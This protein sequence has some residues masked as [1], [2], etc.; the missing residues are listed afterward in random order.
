MKTLN[1]P[2][3]GADMETGKIVKWC[4]EQGTSLKKGDVVALIEIAKGLIEMEVFEDC[5]I[6][7]FLVGLGE[8]IKVGEPIIKVTGI[9]EAESFE[10]T[11]ATKEQKAIEEKAK[12]PQRVREV[13]VS[14]AGIVPA[15]GSEVLASPAAK[16]RAFEKHINLAELEGT[17]PA[18][19]ICLQDVEDAKPKLET[20]KPKSAFDTDQMRQAIAS[21]VSKSKREIPHYYLS[22]DVDL[23]TTEKWLNE[24]NLKQ[25]PEDR[26]MI[27]VPLMCAIARA[28]RKN[29]DFNGL[30]IDGKFQRAGD[31]HL[32]LA[33]RLRNKGLITPAIQNA[34][35]LDAGEMMVKFKSLVER[36]KQGG[37]KQSE[38]QD[39]TV[40]LSN[41]GDRGSDQIF[42]II[43]PPQVAIIGVG[44]VLQKPVVIDAQVL[45]KTMVN[46]S[47][48]A[49]H[50][51]TDGQVGARFLNDIQ[52][53]LKKPSQF[54]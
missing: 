28:L 53:L 45:P 6:Q 15:T 32:G 18:G 54:M 50:R 52:K 16:K 20:E 24:I 17:G 42:G 8:D 46:I 29:P 51:V 13:Q 30:Y 14:M 39:A 27:N 25:S 36:S 12:E 23:T 22:L 49:D 34:D 31:V 1:M 2:S 5:T 40:T 4:V 38:L 21:V 43:F 37:L 44:R 33:I 26:L 41:I 47:L 3:F 19:A 11:E 7:E 9:G 35:K 48:A 10:V